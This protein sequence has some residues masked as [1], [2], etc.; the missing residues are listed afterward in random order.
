MTI[1]LD[2]FVYLNFMSLIG[3]VASFIIIIF[4]I[5]MEKKVEMI[6]VETDK[7]KLETLLK[8]AE[9]LNLSNQIKPHLLFNAL[10]TVISLLHFKQ[11]E[12]AASAIF[13]LSRMLRYTINVKKMSTIDEECRY[14]QDYLEIQTIR[15]GDRLEY[16]LEVD[17][18]TRGIEVPTF[19]LQP[20]VENVCKH[21]L[22]KVD[23]TVS[24]LVKGEIID[25]LVVISIQDNG[26]GMTK[27]KIERFNRWKLDINDDNDSNEYSGIGLK[28]VHKRIVFHFGDNY[29]INIFQKNGTRVEIILPG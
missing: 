16:Q 4:I 22:E 24:I 3:G 26:R 20:M 15:Y 2:G 1:S 9:I 11:A 10:N 28:N 14:L 27:E 19:S 12:K 18:N 5:L 8:E 17:N 23:Y 25:G 21:C 6:D 29:G 7:L 13:N